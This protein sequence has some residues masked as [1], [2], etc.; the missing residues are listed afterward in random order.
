MDATK[1]TLGLTSVGSG[2]ILLLSVFDVIP[3]NQIDSLGVAINQLTGGLSTLILLFMPSIAGMLKK[4][5]DNGE[6]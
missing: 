2:T 4:K 6:D 5:D 1:L 3:A